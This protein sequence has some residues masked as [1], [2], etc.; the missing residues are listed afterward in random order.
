LRVEF[1]DDVFGDGAVREFHEREAAGTTGLAIDRHNDMGRLCDGG[2]VGAKIRFT[3]S[4]RQVPDEQTDCQCSLVK[5]AARA[6]A[7]DSIPLG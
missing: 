3:C 2:K 1:L 6:A 4:V 5:S 7:S